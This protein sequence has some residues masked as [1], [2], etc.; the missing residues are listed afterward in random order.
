MRFNQASLSLSLPLPPSPSPPPS[1]SADTTTLA[2]RCVYSKQS[3]TEGET[4]IT[5]REAEDAYDF[6]CRACP[7]NSYSYL[8]G[9]TTSQ[10]VCADGSCASDKSHC[11][12][13]GSTIAVMPPPLANPVRRTS[14]GREE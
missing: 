12:A 10:V 9:C 7:Q 3:C 8:G 1:P 4:W 2:S 13:R 14:R 11:A 6:G 5:A